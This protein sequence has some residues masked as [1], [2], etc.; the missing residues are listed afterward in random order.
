MSDTGEE[1]AVIG[2]AGFGNMDRHETG[3]GWV[4]C[5]VG[6]GGS[7]T[8]NGSVERNRGKVRGTLE[9]RR[10]KEE[11]A[12]RVEGELNER[13][14]TEVGDDW[15]LRE[16]LPDVPDEIAP[17]ECPAED[18]PIGRSSHAK[19]KVRRREAHR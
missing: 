5:G 1:G 7:S 4:A 9:R 18:D 6:G 2:V 10:G 11:V 17:T 16:F 14:P 3:D 15:G 8:R 12:V 19:C 13:R